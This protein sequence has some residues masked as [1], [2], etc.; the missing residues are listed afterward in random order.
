MD[1]YT[2]N[3]YA[4]DGKSMKESLIHMMKDQILA[5]VMEREEIK[6]PWGFEL[7]YSNLDKVMFAFRV[8]TLGTTYFD[9]EP[10]TVYVPY[11]QWEQH[12]HFITKD[13][14]KNILLG[15][16]EDVIISEK[17]I[18]YRTTFD[19]NNLFENFTFNVIDDII[20]HSDIVSCLGKEEN[21]VY[22][23]DNLETLIHDEN[24]F[25][26]ALISALDKKHEDGVESVESVEDMTYE[27]YA[28]SKGENVH[29]ERTDSFAIAS[30][31][32]T[33]MVNMYEMDENTRVEWVNTKEQEIM[34]WY[35][36]SE[37]K[38]DE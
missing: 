16:V 24:L 30:V 33:A 38:E 34:N 28:I 29:M 36:F 4:E 25:N 37:M 10:K 22:S 17:I 35:E 32:F 31:I 14:I 1:V 11:G 20:Q 13:A 2:F 3:E 6:K 23:K 8:T 21:I 12:K 9:G 26:E 18:E 7:D 15:N 5:D 19:F 27:I